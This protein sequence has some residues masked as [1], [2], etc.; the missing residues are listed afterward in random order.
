[1]ANVEN[2][3]DGKRNAIALIPNILTQIFIIR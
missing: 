3:A 1:M 2:I